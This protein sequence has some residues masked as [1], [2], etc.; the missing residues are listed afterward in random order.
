MGRTILSL[1]GCVVGVVVMVVAVV[2]NEV[3]QAGE[4]ADV[5]LESDGTRGVRL[6]ET[7]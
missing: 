5:R 3:G 1:G 2:M 6:D 7:S 4:K